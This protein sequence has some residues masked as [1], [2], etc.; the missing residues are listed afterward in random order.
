[1]N[2]VINW[3]VALSLTFQW[4]ARTLSALAILNARRKDIT[5]SPIRTSPVPPSHALRMTSS[6][7]Y[8]FSRSDACRPVIYPPPAIAAALPKAT[9]L[10]GAQ[11]A[12]NCP[13]YEEFGFCPLLRRRL[14]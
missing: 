7:P 5:P 2:S 1:M 3:L 6:V 14:A 8:K 9:A 13:G 11:R 10:S 12:S 4:L